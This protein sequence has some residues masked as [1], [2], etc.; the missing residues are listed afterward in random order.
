M[1]AATSIFYA[2]ED[3]SVAGMVLDSCYSSLRLVSEELVD[4]L[5]VK[6]PKFMLGLG[7]K[8][9]RNSIKNKAKF[10]I[11]YFRKSFFC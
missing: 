2:S 9:V 4:K 8:M 5:P 6:L 11:K 3:A 1:G 10:D 7:L